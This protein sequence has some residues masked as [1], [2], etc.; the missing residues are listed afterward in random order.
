M[1]VLQL[2]SLSAVSSFL[3][4]LLLVL[5]LL[6]LLA[7]AKYLIVTGIP[8][9]MSVTGIEL[10][11][12]IAGQG[13]RSYKSDLRMC[14][15]AEKAGGL[16]WSPEVCLLPVGTALEVC[17]LPVGIAED[18]LNGDQDEIDIGSTCTCQMTERNTKVC[19]PVSDGIAVR[20]LWKL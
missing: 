2:L 14:F 5:L 7:V 9:G 12:G 13:G 15:H 1:S 11:E 6:L 19:L 8:V 10:S 16:S 3:W 20:T 4:L 18:L 17:L